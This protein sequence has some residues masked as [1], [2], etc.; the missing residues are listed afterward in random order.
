V[1]VLTADST[2]ATRAHARP[3]QSGPAL[4][5]QVLILSGLEAG[6]RVA[7]SGSF[8]LRENVLVMVAE[9]R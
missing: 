6:E 9:A 2:G 1:F 3:V 4:G 5:D 8:K 7:V